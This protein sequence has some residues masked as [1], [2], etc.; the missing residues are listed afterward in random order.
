MVWV[1][2]I[3]KKKVGF[4]YNIFFRKVVAMFWFLAIQSRSQIFNL[5]NYYSYWV[6]KFVKITSNWHINNIKLL[7]NSTARYLFLTVY[8]SQICWFNDHFIQN[9]PPYY[10]QCSF[11]EKY[12]P[13]ITMLFYSYN[14]LK[15]L[16]IFKI[17]SVC[18]N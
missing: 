4:G 1:F 10:V 5:N 13:K 11:S 12:R 8:W 16:R 17:I 6:K 9:S 18:N 15:I 7:F 3:K 14:I 2:A